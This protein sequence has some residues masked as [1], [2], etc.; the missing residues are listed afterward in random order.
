MTSAAPA[1]SG[2]V[3]G[4]ATVT[5]SG[6]TVQVVGL[7]TATTPEFDL[8]AGTAEIKVTACS[9]NQVPPFVQLYNANDNSLGF[10]VDP[11]YRARN[12]VGGKYYLTVQANPD[13]VWMISLTPG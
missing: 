4:A 8:P 5:T 10:I 1:P 9:S 12:L 11:V 6:S 3:E 2:L 7:G 13:C